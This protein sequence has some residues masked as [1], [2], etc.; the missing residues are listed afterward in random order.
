MSKNTSSI[1]A[2]GSLAFDSIRTP[3]GNADTVLGGSANY[4]SIAASFYAPVHV[5]GVVGEDFPKNHLEWLASRRIG[6]SGVETARGKTFHWVGEYNARLNE[7]NTLS[8]ALN[9]FEH[10]K[11]KLDAG[12][13]ACPIA[14]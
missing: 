7:A 4:F 2:V 12:H 13:K 8:T 3:A 6:V 1:L 14:F 10:F 5:I 9:V 11:P